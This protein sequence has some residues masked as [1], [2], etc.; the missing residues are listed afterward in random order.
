IEHAL[1]LWRFGKNPIK[2]EKGSK[3]KNIPQFNKSNWGSKMCSWTESASQLM[4]E[5]WS[6]QIPT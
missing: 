3:R 5:D 2:D 1:F 4:P 6:T